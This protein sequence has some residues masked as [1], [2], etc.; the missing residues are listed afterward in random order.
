M[1]TIAQD[2][3]F[4]WQEIDAASDLDRLKL[5]LNALSLVDSVHELPLA[6]ELT[7][8]SAGDAPHLIPLV[9]DVKNHHPKI[10]EDTTSDLNTTPSEEKQK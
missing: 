10:H 7:K 5:V 9:E 8:A 2:W 3:L 1:A 4:N 6:F